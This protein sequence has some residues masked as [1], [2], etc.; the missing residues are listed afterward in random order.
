MRSERPCALRDRSGGPGKDSGQ[1]AVL[2][3]YQT[4]RN[5]PDPKTPPSGGSAKSPPLTFHHAEIALV[6]VIES[7]VPM[8]HVLHDW[9]G[10][11]S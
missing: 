1:K 2:V 11:R 7:R 4:L 6:H 9:G 10:R 5:A 3:T 8:H